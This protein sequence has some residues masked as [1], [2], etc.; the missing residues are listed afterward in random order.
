MAGNLLPLLLVGGAAAYVVTSQKKKTEEA[1]CPP[2]NE[3]TF[4]QMATASKKVQLKFKKGAD[5]SAPANDYVRELLPKGCNRASKDSEVVIVVDLEDGDKSESF[6]MTV[7]DLYM[8]AV[9][10]I[11]DTFFQAGFINEKKYQQVVNR[12]LTWYKELMGKQFDP[13][14]LNLERLAE[15]MLEAVMQATESILDDSDRP[16][17]TPGKAAGSNCPSSFSITAADLE[18]RLHSEVKNGQE[19]KIPSVAWAEV[20]AGNRDVM[21]M[22]R[23]VFASITPS[24]CT[25]ETEGVD[26]TLIGPS[27]DSVVVNPQEAFLK[28]WAD[29]AAALVALE[30]ISISEITQ[31]SKS[32]ESWWANNTGGAPLPDM[33]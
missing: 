14:S 30:I 7:P 18:S 4:G 19:F 20:K 17:I 5:P 31:Q 25:P 11:T 12:E 8:L 3:V 15:I 32:L 2:T 29:I 24:G 22:A 33:I 27:G 23:K 1:E 16:N 26:I 9:S 13:A 6:T 21:D 28:L 10:S